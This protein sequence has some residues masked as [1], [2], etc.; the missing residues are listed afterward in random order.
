MAK[1]WAWVDFLRRYPGA[2]LVA[3]IVIPTRAGPHLR[4]LHRLLDQSLRELELTSD[5]ATTIVRPTEVVQ[6]YCAFAEKTDADHVA[7]MTK[8]RAAAPLPGWSSHRS[9]QLDAAK[10]VALAA[11]PRA[12]APRGRRTRTAGR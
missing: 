5:Y 8:A 11:P 9:F 4:E 7:R 6:I 2:Y 3:G 1:K 12:H 10:E